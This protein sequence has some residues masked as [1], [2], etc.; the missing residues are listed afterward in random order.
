MVNSAVIVNKATYALPTDLYSVGSSSPTDVS[1][2]PEV[3]PVVVTSAPLESIDQ[4]YPSIYLPPLDEYADEMKL[5]S[6]YKL[7]ST[8]LG[9]PSLDEYADESLDEM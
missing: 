8:T 9:L 6:L 2:M 3:Y 5:Y 7:P 1:S 4:E